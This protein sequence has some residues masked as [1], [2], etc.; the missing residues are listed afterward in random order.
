MRAY[1]WKKR[2]ISQCCLSLP[3]SVAKICLQGL[4]QRSK[5]KNVYVEGLVQ[6]LSS[7]CMCSAACTHESPTMCC[8]REGFAIKSCSRGPESCPGQRLE[9]RPFT[10]VV[11]DTVLSLVVVM[12]WWWWWYL[13]W[14]EKTRNK[15]KPE[16]VWKNLALV[17]GPVLDFI[18]S[19]VES[20]SRLAEQDVGSD[21]MVLSTT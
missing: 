5:G 20:F 3:L 15:K 2:K 6:D 8:R 10:Q 12:G 9:R 21:F 14:R 4:I 19:N 7:A 1:R 17:F 11:A 13:R 16:H 18:F